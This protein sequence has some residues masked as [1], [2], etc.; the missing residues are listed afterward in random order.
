[1]YTVYCIQYDTCELEV[2]GHYDCLENANNKLEQVAL[3][4]MADEEG[5]KQAVIYNDIP[6]NDEVLEGYFL[7]R[8]DAR[9]EETM[10]KQ[11]FG[12]SCKID[13]YLRRRNFVAGWVGTNME[14]VTRKVKFYSIGELKDDEGAQNTTVPEWGKKKFCNV[15]EKKMGSE[16]ANYQSVI[17][18]FKKKLAMKVSGE[19]SEDEC[20]EVDDIIDEITSIKSDTEESEAEYEDS[21]DDR[22]E[23]EEEE[24]EEETSDNEASDKEDKEEQEKIKEE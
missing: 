22:S 6:S 20:V 12:Q 3:E 19:S 17:N 14:V 16:F 4:F 21:E 24:E 2:F 9:R 13:V 23:E 15:F 7:C 8:Y 1:M 11:S 10:P 5:R 18:E